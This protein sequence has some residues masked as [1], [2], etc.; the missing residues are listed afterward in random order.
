MKRFP[1]ATAALRRRLGARVVRTDEAE[2]AEAGLDGSKLSVRPEARIRV[3]R[4]ADVG[5]VLALANRYRVPVTTRGRGTTLTGAAV[6]VHGG[7]V[8]D[9]LGLD[10]IRIDQP[11]ITPQQERHLSRRQRSLPV[12]DNRMHIF[13]GHTPRHHRSNCQCFCI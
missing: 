8:L 2:L 9:L 10:A 1:A 5:V 12:G 7:W 11:A 4:E 6:P 13:D 3:R